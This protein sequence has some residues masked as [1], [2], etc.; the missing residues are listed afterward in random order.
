MGLEVR[1]ELAE[2]LLRENPES[3]LIA[4]IG[5][6]TEICSVFDTLSRPVRH[7]NTCTVNIRRRIII[8]CCENSQ[9]DLIDSHFEDFSQ[10]TQG[11]GM[12]CLFMAMSKGRHQGGH[13]RTW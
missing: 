6:H 3:E 1:S 5:G 8:M 9:L 12:R 10:T 7:R 13:Y 11:H 2:S 4:W